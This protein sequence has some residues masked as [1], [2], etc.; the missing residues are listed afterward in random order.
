MGWNYTN[1]AEKSK[2]AKGG[3]N[4]TEFYKLPEDGGFMGGRLKTD[5]G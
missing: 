4:E 5:S 1:F 2:R 3:G